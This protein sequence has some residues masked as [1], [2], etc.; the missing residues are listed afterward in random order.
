MITN[1]DRL[2]LLVLNKSGEVYTRYVDIPSVI[3]FLNRVGARTRNYAVV[4]HVGKRSIF[5]DDIT[6]E[7]ELTKELN[8]FAIQHPVS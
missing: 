4:A 6:T 7:K 2:E 3:A 8:T 5:I 1:N